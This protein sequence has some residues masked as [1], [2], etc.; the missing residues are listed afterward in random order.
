MNG[1]ISD[2]IFLIK[3]NFLAEF[4][5]ILTMF[6]IL[7]LM[8]AVVLS[9]YGQILVQPVVSLISRMTIIRCSNLE[10]FSQVHV[11]HHL[12]HPELA[13]EA[14]LQNSAWEQQLPVELQKSSRF[15]S[16]PRTAAH[17]AQES[18]FTDKE[19]PVFSRKAEE[20]DRDQIGKIFRN[21]GLQKRR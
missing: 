9:T 5:R 7:L 4:S 3:K 18:W 12:S 15:Y 14:V 21:A 1:K 11:A 20:I 19:N 8:S 6:K 2:N 13:H 17:L 10:F 16:N